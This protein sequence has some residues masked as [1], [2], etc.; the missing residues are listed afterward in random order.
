MSEKI[1]VP[2]LGESIT[3]AT[4]VKWLKSK[5][6]SVEIDEPIVELE[7]DK[8]NLEVPSPVDGILSE[9]NAKEGQVVEVGTV[10]GLVTNGKIEKPTKEVTKKEQTIE[11]L[12]EINK[13]SPKLFENNNIVKLEKSSV[14]KQ[15]QEQPLILSN[16]IT[17]EPIVTKNETNQTLSPS[18]RKIVKEKNID[19]KNISGSGK[20]GRILKGDLINLMSS[21]PKPSDRKVRYGQEER[22]R[23]TRL[24]MTIAKRLKQAQET[25]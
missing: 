1:L 6:D 5:G 20:E 7:T 17:T 12:S 8:V 9:I 19:T 16:E 25:Y 23:M 21:M 4:V 10:L 14:I 24:R 18:V 2:A 15:N 22:I 3:E 13:H 11:K